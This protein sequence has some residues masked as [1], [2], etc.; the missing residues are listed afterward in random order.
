MKHFKRLKYYLLFI[1]LAVCFCFLA[2]ILERNYYCYQR[3]HTIPEAPI[4]PNS[5]LVET[6]EQHYSGSKLIVHQ[7]TVTDSPEVVKDFFDSEGTCSLNERNE[8]YSCWGTANPFGSYNVI[9]ET[10]SATLT[11]FTITINWD[12]CSSRF[13]GLLLEK[14]KNLR[15]TRDNTC[16][17][18]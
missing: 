4:P 8:R 15:Q 9:I 17:Q 13:L 12:I 14:G 11:M 10:R 7:Y 18:S 3:N 5:T 1:F 6:S 2:F 16:Y